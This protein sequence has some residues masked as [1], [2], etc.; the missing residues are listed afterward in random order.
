MLLGYYRFGLKRIIPGV[1]SLSF[2]GAGGACRA[3]GRRGGP[4]PLAHDEGWGLAD[5][6]DHS[7]DAPTVRLSLA[8]H[9]NL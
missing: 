8:T 2:L 5:R 9:L 6:T 3:R 4:L 1:G 7:A